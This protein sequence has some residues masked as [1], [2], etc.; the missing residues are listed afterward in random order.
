Q[1]ERLVGA[2]PQHQGAVAHGA[3]SGE[4]AGMSD[5]V[6]RFAGMGP[7]QREPI[8]IAH[9]LTARCAGGEGEDEDEGGNCNQAVHVRTPVLW[10]HADGPAPKAG[11]PARRLPRDSTPGDYAR[12][13]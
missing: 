1:Q 13:V 8:G 7:E 11:P 4:T 6:D 10:D 3:P 2:W 12:P 9:P 5:R